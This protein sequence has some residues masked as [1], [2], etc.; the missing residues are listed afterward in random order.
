MP[1][2]QPNAQQFD[3]YKYLRIF[4]RRKWLLIIPVAIFLPIS[5]VAPDILLEEMVLTPLNGKRTVAP[6]LSRPMPR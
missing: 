5:I 6:Y 1:A 3:L 2:T 4:W